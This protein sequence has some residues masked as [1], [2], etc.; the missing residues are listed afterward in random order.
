MS[1]SRLPTARW[2]DGRSYAATI[3]RLLSGVRGYVA[4]RLPD[5]DRVL[6]ACC[7]TGSLSLRL[8]H[9]DGGWWA[10]TCVEDDRRID[11]G[12]LHVS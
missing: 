6:D 12:T 10:S 11:S 7:G 1:G 9:D 8:A 4:D 3:D 5:G 2:Y